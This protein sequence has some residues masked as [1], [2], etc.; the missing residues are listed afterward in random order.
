MFV[1]Q[2]QI[3]LKDIFQ[4]LSKNP[5]IDLPENILQHR[6]RS[7]IYSLKKSGEINRVGN[8]TYRIK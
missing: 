2:N 7:T 8:S 3:T 5:N 1:E 4:E 6:I